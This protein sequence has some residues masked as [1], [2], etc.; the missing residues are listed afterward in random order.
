MPRQ[1]FAD[2]F[3]DVFGADVELFAQ[4]LPQDLLK[5]PLTLTHVFTK[6]CVDQLGIA[7]P[8]SLTG[9]PSQPVEDVVVEPKSDA[10]FAEL[11]D[12]DEV[13]AAMMLSL[14]SSIQRSRPFAIAALRP[15]GSGPVGPPQAFRTPP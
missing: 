13:P 3:R 4:D 7:L 10:S 11:L 12:H 2:S 15:L 6:R 9:L 1:L 8:P 5:R 14:T